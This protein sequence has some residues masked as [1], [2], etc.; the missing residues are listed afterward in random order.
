MISRPIHILIVACSL[1]LA[2][3]PGW[4]CLLEGPIFGQGGKK[5]LNTCGAC[6][7]DHPAKHSDATPGPV[8]ASPRPARC[9]CDDRNSTSPDPV[10]AKV[11]CG[12]ALPALR[13]PLSP[14]SPC[15]IENVLL[16]TDRVCLDGS[17]HLL[18]CTWLC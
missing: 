12:I 10:S 11:D 15:L 4:C 5:K 16:G 17:L 18:N 14:L 6:C 3:P 1:L 9:P 7:C 2:L 8:P 13:T